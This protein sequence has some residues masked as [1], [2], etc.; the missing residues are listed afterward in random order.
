MKNEAN[1]GFLKSEKAT[2]KRC[3]VLLKKGLMYF[4]KSLMF[5]EQGL[6]FFSRPIL[7]IK[8]RQ[9]FLLSNQMYIFAKT[10]SLFFK[11]SNQNQT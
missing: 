7:R 9:Y 4:E 8:I 2:E 6:G 1:I 10:L 11:P 5:F 3:A